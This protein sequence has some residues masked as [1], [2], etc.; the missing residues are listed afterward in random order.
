MLQKMIILIILGSVL[1]SSFSLIC[2]GYELEH[3]ES[4]VDAYYL[5]NFEY[6]MV[7]AAENIDK[8][9]FPSSTVKIMTACVALES[10]IS[11]NT[12]VTINS[13]MLKDVS[14]RHMG[15]KIG[16]KLTFED[17]LYAM[18]C[19]GFNDAA[20]AIALT[21]CSS[22]AEFVDLMNEKASVLGMDY[23][24]YLNVTGMYT[25]GMFTT[26][27]DI[28]ILAKY[29]AENQNF[30]DICS[31]KSYKPS[32]SAT[33]DYKTINNRSSLLASYKGMANL[34]TGSGESGD[35]A[36][37]YY[38]KDGLT[39]ISIVMN[40]SAYDS[41]DST[42]YAELYSKKL[43]SHALNDYSIRSVAD[44]KTT[45]ASLPVKYSISNEEIGIYLQSDVKLYLSDE[46]DI[47]N[48]LNYS[49][50][51]YGN[52]LKAPINSGDTVGK[53]IVSQDG[54][55]LASVPLV[56]KEAVEKSS[57]L[58]FMDIMKEYITS[59]AFVFTVIVFIIA[60]V[61]YYAYKRSNLKKMYNRRRN[62]ISMKNQRR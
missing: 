56:V 52:E 1:F 11:M 40:V 24:N 48:D 8:S 7:M 21:V 61:S 36:V 46:T 20:Q 17:L 19:A 37:L 54:K 3:E 9:I 13:A 44:T 15:L 47:E 33:I 22:I 42:N 18:I 58:Y 57:F 6:D 23:T 29:M 45:I 50:Y 26:T 43:F 53:L 14:G 25:A 59:R 30:V 38:K 55:I 4:N 12:L 32:I 39:F 34:N 51:I 60:M 35:C 49:I 62:N 5:Y 31:T 2:S 41:S 28:A 10:G 27:A 16:D